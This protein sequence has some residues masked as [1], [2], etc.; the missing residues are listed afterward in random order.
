M[1]DPMENDPA[2]PDN[3][4]V[5]TALWRALHIQVDAPPY[6]IEDTMG[7]QLAEPEA[8]WQQRPDMHADYTKRPRAAM[9]ARAR[10][11]DDLVVAQNAAGT[12]QYVLLGAGLDT[13]AWRRPGV[14]ASMQLYEIDQPGTQAWKQQRLQLLDWP[15]P[16]GL[17]FVPVDFEQTTWWEQLIGAGFDLQLPAVVSCTGVTLYLTIDAIKDTLQQT[18]SLAP[19]STLAMTFYLPIQLMAEEDQPLQQI[20][21]KGAREAGTPF[22]SFFAPEQVLTMAG[23]AGFK[24]ARIVSARDLEQRYFS[25]RT[26]GLAPASGEY[27]LLAGT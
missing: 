26:D 17:H 5:R 20:A 7:L 18:A 8:G 2:Q 14:A 15:M 19:G 27:F 16:T 24:S 11:I 12:P 6:I 3:T 13:F 25:G 10:F 23:E 9:V 21:E 1:I 4:A 22:L